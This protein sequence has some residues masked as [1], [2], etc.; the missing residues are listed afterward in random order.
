MKTN[1]NY[2]KSMNTYEYEWKAMKT[3]ENRL[4]SAKIKDKL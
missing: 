4:K 3:H 2:L 1:Y